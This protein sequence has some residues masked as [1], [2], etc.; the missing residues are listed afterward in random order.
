MGTVIFDVADDHV[1]SE[2]GDD[3]RAAWSRCRVG[4]DSLKDLLVR[5][6]DLPF[7]KGD[8]A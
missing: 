3:F 1:E 5:V 7:E 2:H 6:D 4:A 8:H